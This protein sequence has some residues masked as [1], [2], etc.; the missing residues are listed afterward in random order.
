[1]NFNEKHL[2]KCKP[3]SFGAD[4]KGSSGQR[5]ESTN[6]FLASFYFFTG[7]STLSPDI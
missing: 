4:E 7:K 3:D 2:K 1:M 6:K 5:I